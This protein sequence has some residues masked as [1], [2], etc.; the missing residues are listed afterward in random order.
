MSRA[1]TAIVP[2]PRTART[3]AGF[4]ESRVFLPVFMD[5]QLARMLNR[6]LRVRFRDLRACVRIRGPYPRTV[7]SFMARRSGGAANRIGTDPVRYLDWRERRRSS[8]RPDET[9]LHRQDERIA[10]GVAGDAVLAATRASHEGRHGRR[11]RVG[12]PG[13]HRTATYDRRGNPD[14]AIEHGQGR[15]QPL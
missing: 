3:A 2:A 15:P 9:G 4:G 7:H 6:G 13:S 11:D 12:G 5:A 10:E 14:G 1:R 8:G